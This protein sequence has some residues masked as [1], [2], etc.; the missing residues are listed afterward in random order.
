MEAASSVKGKKKGSEVQ[1][2]KS[3]TSRAVAGQQ[4]KNI[5]KEGIT[6]LIKGRFP[7]DLVIL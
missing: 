6:Q 1:N 3:V 2:F 7:K 5:K 4:R